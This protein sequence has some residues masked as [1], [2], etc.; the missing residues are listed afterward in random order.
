MQGRIIFYFILLLLLVT[1][2]QG[3]TQNKGLHVVSFA[4]SWKL[5]ARIGSTMMLSKVPDQYLG[6]LHNVRPATFVPGLNASLSVRKAF[7]GHL[8]MGYQVQ[9]IDIS[10]DV[11]QA[12]NTYSVHTQGIEH[13]TLFLLNL[14]RT[15]YYRPAFNAFTYFKI[16]AILLK[17]TPRLRLPNGDLQTDPSLWQNT[18][19]I[20]N[21]G[22]AHGLGI[23]FNH[24]INP[25]LSLV[26]TI[27]YNRTFNVV[28]DIYKIQKLFIS[29]PTTVNH[30]ASLSFGL[31]YTFNFVEPSKRSKFYNAE[32]ETVRQLKQAKLKKQRDKW[33]SRNNKFW[34]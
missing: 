30:Y 11:D 34:S 27:D 10:G 19:F 21:A 29:S 28:S 1:A 8:E 14:K 3:F 17:N 16:T 13:N 24:Q 26:G 18:S 31:S 32:R 20:E 6:I 9:Y 25:N 4:Q 22:V 33:K 2:L 7:T 15:D 12:A 23:G 5:D